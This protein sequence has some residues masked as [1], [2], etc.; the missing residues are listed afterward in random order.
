SFE[1]LQMGKSIQ[2][3]DSQAVIRE[4]EML[5]F[6]NAPYRKINWN[7]FLRSSGISMK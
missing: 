3:Y 4:Y 1:L 2:V 5:I 7:Q 6:F